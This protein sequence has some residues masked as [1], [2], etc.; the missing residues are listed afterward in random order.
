MGNCIRRKAVNDYGVVKHDSAPPSYGDAINPNVLD[1]VRSDRER[2]VR[3]AWQTNAPDLITLIYG[4]QIPTDSFGC[5]LH[6]HESIDSVSKRAIRILRDIYA[7]PPD[8]ETVL[9]TMEMV[10]EENNF[11]VDREMIMRHE[12]IWRKRWQDDTM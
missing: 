5:G 2:T 11:I 10:M 6:G 12:P 8:V 3:E 4:N 9:R 7:S 1:C